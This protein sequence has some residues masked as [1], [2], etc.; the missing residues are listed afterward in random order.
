M[1]W[2]LYY[3]TKKWKEITLFKE[4]DSLYIQ[5]VG[6][7]SWNIGRWWIEM[8]FRWCGVLAILVLLEFRYKDKGPPL[9][10]KKWE[11]IWYH[12]DLYTIV[13]SFMHGI[14]R[15][16][17]LKTSVPST[18][19]VTP[20][21]PVM[22]LATYK[23]WSRV[24]I[25]NRLFN[26]H[27]SKTYKGYSLFFVRW[28]YFKYIYGVKKYRKHVRSLVHDY[29]SPYHK[30]TLLLKKRPEI[31]TLLAPKNKKESWKKYEK[32]LF[33]LPKSLE[34]FNYDYSKY[35]HTS[36]F[37]FYN[38]NWDDLK[39][40]SKSKNNDLIDF[41]GEKHIKFN[42]LY[43]YTK[44][45]EVIPRI[46][47]PNIHYD[48][49][50][51]YPSL[52]K[53]RRVIR[54]QKRDDWG[55][56]NLKLW[57]D[58]YK[59]RLA[60]KNMDWKEGGKIKEYSMIK[61]SRNR[62]RLQYKYLNLLPSRIY[63]NQID[64]FKEY[65]A[66]VF[67]SRGLLNN[68]VQILIKRD[69]RWGQE[70]LKKLGFGLIEKKGRNYS[71]RIRDPQDCMKFYQLIKGRTR[72]YRKYRVLFRYLEIYVLT[73]NLN[74]FV[75]NPL[76]DELD[77]L[78]NIYF[79]PPNDI[80]IGFIKGLTPPPSFEVL[81]GIL[82][83]K[84]RKVK[85]ISLTAYGPSDQNYTPIRLPCPKINT[86]WYNS[87]TER[88]AWLIGFLEKNPLNPFLIQ[89][90]FQLSFV[91]PCRKEFYH[92]C[93]HLHK[94]CGLLSSFSFSPPYFRFSIS[95]P[96]VLSHFIRLFQFYPFYTPRL[97]RA[98]AIWSGE[99]HLLFPLYSSSRYSFTRSILPLYINSFF[100][101]SPSPSLYYSSVLRYPFSS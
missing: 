5:F 94:E 84:I 75:Y 19:S 60:L 22:A 48:W 98:F 20:W 66:G 33:D 12:E 27:W 55:G 9:E 69:L 67:E 81:E 56:L 35:P 88:S 18:I 42:N 41:K 44:Q 37:K 8:Y 91:F 80:E 13:F 3:K 53:S 68:G 57:E 16:L 92:F 25:Q 89:P 1:M 10:Y 38:F 74:T 52:E 49:K 59:K 39:Y 96:Q 47:N 24:Y 15:G 26:N 36:L 85:G 30:R 17:H 63:D 31:K 70:I 101:R 23:K 83:D 61:K 87:L 62:V 72:L 54:N 11:K 43:K 45:S 2:D 99:F 82:Q 40:K 32:R 21:V 76:V 95:D 28:K 46:L 65:M 7:T 77:L 100:P 78:N 50:Y 6:I 64:S 79:C 86:F 14:S 34:R 58:R 90:R 93:L 29:W 97:N 71:I 4:W 51:L 73:T